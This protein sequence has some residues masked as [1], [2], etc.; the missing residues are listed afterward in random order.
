MVEKLTLVEVIDEFNKLK[1]AE[2]NSDITSVNKVLH[3]ETKCS[4]T[5]FKNA[6]RE[7]TTVRA[8]LLTSSALYPIVT[9]LQNW[10]NK[11]MCAWDDVPKKISFSKFQEWIENN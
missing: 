9:E 11:M 8:T 1:K 6:M 10:V 3:S 7:L 2:C 5:Q 4:K